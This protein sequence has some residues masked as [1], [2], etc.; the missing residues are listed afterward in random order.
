MHYCIGDHPPPLAV[1]AYA[2]RA[3]YMRRPEHDITIH[4]KIGVTWTYSAYIIYIY[5]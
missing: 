2:Y 3:A 1:K 5:K 4:L